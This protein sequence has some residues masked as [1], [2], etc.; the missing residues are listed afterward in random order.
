MTIEK[1]SGV[2]EPFNQWIRQHPQLGSAED[3]AALSIQDVDFIIHK[4]VVADKANGRQL[5]RQHIMLLE[6]KCFNARSRKAQRDTFNAVSAMLKAGHLKKVKLW[7]GRV[8]LFYH[9]FHT[10]RFSGTYPGDSNTIKWDG[11]LITTPTLVKL[12]GFELD[13]HTLRPREDRSHHKAHPALDEMWLQ[14]TP[15]QKTHAGAP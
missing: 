3:E 7:R 6:H 4:Y 15:G 12:L 13:A 9:G 5:P 2:E 11:K 1:R 10:V 8:K 14:P